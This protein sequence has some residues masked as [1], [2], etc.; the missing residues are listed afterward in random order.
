MKSVRMLILALGLVAL[1]AA[2]SFAAVPFLT[3]S[4]TNIF[5]IN[6]QTGLAGGILYTPQA[7]GT[8]RAGEIVNISYPTTISY[9]SDIQIFVTGDQGTTAINEVFGAPAAGFT[10]AGGPFTAY[11]PT[12]TGSFFSSSASGVTV[13]VNQTSILIAFAKDLSFN[14]TNTAH[15]MKITGVRLDTSAMA[16]LGGTIIANLSNTGNEAM[17]LNPNLQV[18]VFQEPLVFATPAVV[19][20]NT[21]TNAVNFFSNA[22]VNG[23]Q[24]LVTVALNEV[25]PNAFE[26]KTNAWG[27]AYANTKIR[28]TLGNI[29]AGMKISGIALEGVNGATFN[30]GQMPTFGTSPAITTNPL[31]FGI[32]T[33]NGNSLQGLKVGITFGITSGTTYLALNPGNI[34]VTVTL[35]PPAPTIPAAYPGAGGPDYPFSNPIFNTSAAPLYYYQQGQLKYV[36]RTISTTIPVIITALQSNLLSPFN[37]AIRDTADASMFQYDTGIAISNTSGTNPSGSNPAGLPGTIK[38]LLYPIDGS[39]PKSFETGSDSAMRPGL[40]LSS[41]G[42]L[43]PKAT[44]VV[45]LTQLLGPAGFSSTADFRGFIRFQCNFQGAIG[46]AYIA[47]AYFTETGNS[48]GYPML[49]DVPYIINSSANTSTLNFF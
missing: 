25:F 12:A 7:T 11:G 35:D 33:Q 41:S 39:G 14:I 37:L 32:A 21:T 47:D 15:S 27:V 31:V 49:S 29:P 18:G 28:M 26:T 30:N 43:A 5:A 6:A 20:S 48:Q 2:S 17:H 45:L 19:G 4:N 42:A 44:W 24:N 1:A 23:A 40:G 3:T 9:L 38:V 8:V 16:T 13:T 36:A 34:T 22:T 10:S 46:I